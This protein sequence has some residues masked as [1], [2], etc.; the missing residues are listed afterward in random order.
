MSLRQIGGPIAD[1]SDL[2]AAL[3]ARLEE[4][5]VS[6]AEVDAQ[7]DLPAGYTS[8]RLAIPQIKYFG[9]DAFWDIAEAMGLA[10]VLVEDPNATARHAVR[11]KSRVK[12]YARI[13]NSHWNART[14]C[15]MR[16]IARKHGLEGARV[17]NIRTGKRRR[18]QIARRA[19]QI[20]WER[21]RFHLGRVD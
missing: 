21:A 2:V 12:K 5:N 14:L 20:R 9:R 19:A 10:V 15:I 18:K 7:C 4:I 17:K 16:D 1:E 3:R 13:D 8:K 6:R 11:M